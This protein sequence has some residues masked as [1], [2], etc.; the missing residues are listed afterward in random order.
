M[1]LGGFL[2]KVGGFVGKAASLPV[3]GVGR[4]ARGKFKEGLGDILGGAARTAAIAV[5]GLGV[6]A[7]GVLAGALGSISGG[8]GYALGSI[9]GIKGAGGLSGALKGVGGFLKDN[10]DLALAGLGTLQGAQAQGRSDELL[11]QALT[12][13]RQRDL[14]L[15]P[16]RAM[17]IEGLQREP[18]QINVDDIYGGPSSNSFKRAAP[19]GEVGQLGIL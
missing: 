9:G 12:L 16:L 15:A 17:T 13:A 7:P 1:G 19:T 6:V 18:T 10:P 11:G 4:I 3:R 8:V 2:K 5:P 14:Q